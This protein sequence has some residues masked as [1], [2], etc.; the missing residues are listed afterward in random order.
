M[1][2]GR[3]GLKDLAPPLDL[4]ADFQR[5]KA[6]RKA[7][8]DDAALAHAAAFERVRYRDRYLRHVRSDA[9]AVAALRAVVGDASAADLYLMC[10]CPYRTPAEACHTYLLLELARELAPALTIL[11]EPEPRRPAAAARHR[12]VASE[13]TPEVP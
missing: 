7:H 12:R 9:G 6:A 1:R 3:A 8:G 5:E 4:F 13:G 10:M 2:A 11:P